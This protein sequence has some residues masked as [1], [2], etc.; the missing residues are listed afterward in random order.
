MRLLLSAAVVVVAFFG[1]AGFALEKA[2]RDAAQKAIQDRLQ[3]HIYT[4]LASIDIDRHG[5]LRQPHHLHEARFSSPGSG[6]YAYV[7]SHG[8][9]LWRSASAL[10]IDIPSQTLESGASIFTH[11]R[12]K[13]DL[14]VL[15]YGVSWE[16]TGGRPFPLVLAVAEDAQSLARQVT[17][18]RQT[19]W[20]WLGG[21]G[22]FLLIF[23]GLAMRWNLRPLEVIAR[24]LEA[25]EGGRKD[26]LEGDY[27]IEL[28][29][30]TGNLNALLQS[31]RAHLERYRNSLADLA[32]SL[33][34]P[35]AVLRGLPALA[36]PCQ[37]ISINVSEQI[38]R[39]QTLVDY[40]LQRA[41]ARGARG[42]LG[43]VS[44][45]PLLDKIRS[46]LQ[47]VYAGKGIVCDL[48]GDDCL[49]FMDSGDL[50][51]LGG[52]LLDNAFK[53]CRQRVSITIEAVDEPGKRHP[54]LK[55]TVEDDGP[56]IPEAMRREVLQR[57]IRADQSTQG[58]GIGLAIVQDLVQL[59]QGT[60]SYSQSSLGGACWQVL[61]PSLM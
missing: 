50:Y 46:S 25:I 60:L 28:Q 56:G 55:L 47:K 40:Q 4:L 42:S 15:Y 51:E 45:R 21:S 14:W 48:N 1:L 57:G 2:F 54:G 22:I 16:T 11:Q 5:N 6:L 9:L 27:P 7:F 52:N 41:A 44:I 59:H 29:G 19:L 53:W 61:I 12:D 26:H 30:L 18:F 13:H 3:A 10:A 23:Q 39:M 17:D 8:R 31:E 24:D 43:P 35:L 34:T 20:L 33:K 58:H 37:E 38:D 32:H 49:C 36:G